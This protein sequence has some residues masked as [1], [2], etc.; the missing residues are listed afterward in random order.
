[1][2]NAA[3][4]GFIEVVKLLLEKGANVN[5][6]MT[7]Y[8]LDAKIETLDS[9]S[10]VTARVMSVNDD[11]KYQVDLGECYTS[12]NVPVYEIRPLP[13]G[14]NVQGGVTAFLLAAEK[15]HFEVAELLLKSGADVNN[16]YPGGRCALMHAAEKGNLDFLNTL[17]AQG[18]SVDLAMS[19]GMTAL[20]FAASKSH[21]DC[22]EALIKAGAN[23]NLVGKVA[24]H[25]S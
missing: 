14:D 13:D 7:C 17:L 10:W 18:A 15:G 4:K 12:D 6:T 22:V 23:V 2:I 25:C 5:A 19:D 1:M 24:T 11:Y 3:R 20:H 16:Q 21:L 9:G 8:A